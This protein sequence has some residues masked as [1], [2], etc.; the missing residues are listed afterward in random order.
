LSEL[1]QE[2]EGQEVASAQG[3]RRPL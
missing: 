2:E 3:G 1:Q